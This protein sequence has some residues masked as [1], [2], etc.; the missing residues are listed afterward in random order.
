M[1]S[2]DTRP[3]PEVVT[4]MLCSAALTAQLVGGKATRDALFLAQLSVTSLPTMVMVTS[5]ASIALVVASSKA[6]ARLTPSI[7]VPIAFWASAILF[8]LE[9]A[10]TSLAPRVAPVLVYLHMSALGPVLASGFWLIATE[11]FDPRTAKKRFGHIAGAG[12]LGGI[13]GGLIAERAGA[14][15][16]MTAVLPLLAVLNVIGGIAV[17]RLASVEGSRAAAAPPAAAQSRSLG[18]ESMQSGW[19]VLT[20]VP[21]I[22]HLA[23]LVLLGTMSAALVDYIFKVQA[24]QT[25]GRGGALLRFFAIYYTATSVVTFV[26]QASLSRFVL[27]RFGLAMATSLPSVAVLAGSLL[28]VVA[29]D[30]RSIIGV[31]SG[32]TIFRG[33]LF[34][35]GYELFYT[36]IPAAQKRSVKSI[37][38]V[39]FDR[40]GDAVGA[41]IIRIVLVSAPAAQYSVLLFLAIALSGAAVIVAS[42]LN[43]GYIRSLE[44]SLMNRAVEFD[45]SDVQDSTT[46]TTMIKTLAQRRGTVEWPG[47]ENA[48]APANV[49]TVSAADPE[50]QEI[51]WL[52]SRD[53]DQ[54]R[55]VLRRD[56]CLTPG[57][58]PHVIPLLAWG[59]VAPDAVFALRKVAE[60]RVGELTDAL[61]DPNQDFAVRRRL[62]RVFSVCISQRAA[63][64]LMLGLED[65]RFEVRFQCGRSLS[66]VVDKNPRVRIDRERILAVILGEVAVARPVWEGRRLLDGLDAGDSDSFVD[67][68]VR[69]RAGQ[70][71][72]HVFTLLSFVMPK[73]PL[74]IAF[75]GLH[76]G[77][78]NL[79]GT[80]LEYLEGMLPQSIREHLWPFLEDSRPPSRSPRPREEILADLLRSNQSIVMNLEELKRQNP[81]EPARDVEPVVVTSLANPFDSGA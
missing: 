55:K 21:Y 76:T 8:L 61:I 63:D 11:S 40:L 26:V 36:P 9:W 56:E 34:R 12:T 67:D 38:D 62:A 23:A 57:L 37:I 78:Q 39:G 48:G 16:G 17:R 74:L 66:A 30:F 33:S 6:M 64:S 51:L 45:L 42:R 79:R 77:D 65:L 53:A 27:E 59:P 49:A 1:T 60:E 25:L 58:V 15:F 14:I 43:Q 22:R 80:A 31:R 68:F 2:A 46:R 75:R 69:D 7:F 18:S 3:G 29:P 4:A 44:Q 70:S 32:E 35:F 52:R 71:L 24:V 19:R 50:V 81:S 54:V 5:V 72:A 28:S 13:F 73:E 47:S 20:D 10:L 41:G